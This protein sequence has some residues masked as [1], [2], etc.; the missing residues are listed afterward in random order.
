MLLKLFMS[1]KIWAYSVNKKLAKVNN[2]RRG[3]NMSNLVKPTF[4]IVWPT[5]GPLAM[6]RAVAM[7]A[8]ATSLSM[9]GPSGLNTSGSVNGSNSSSCRKRSK[10]IE[11]DRKISKKDRKGRKRSKR[12]KKFVILS[13]KEQNSLKSHRL[14]V[15]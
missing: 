7:E 8:R 1:P 3:K 9:P 14:P 5:I 6:C 2:R 15:D 4:F 12:S 11:K 10:K 13:K